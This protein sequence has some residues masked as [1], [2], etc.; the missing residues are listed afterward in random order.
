MQVSQEKEVR[1]KDWKG[2][3]KLSLLA[4]NTILKVSNPKKSIINY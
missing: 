1:H 4:N 2:N 3:I